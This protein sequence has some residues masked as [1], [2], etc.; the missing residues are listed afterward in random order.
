M[1]RES[2]LWLTAAAAVAVVVAA[3]VLIFGY[4]RPPDF[5]DLYA[6]GGPTV[7]GTVAYLEFN[8]EEC[9]WILD[10]ASGDS[11]ELYCDNWIW[12]EGW[13]AEGNLRVHADNGQAQLLLLDPDSGEVVGRE[14]MWDGPPSDEGG[15]PRQEEPLLRSRSTEGRVTLTHGT[16]ANAV[17]LIDIA[18]PRNYRF[19]LYG[20]TADGRYAWVW[21]SEDR[22]LLVA[23][24][25]DAEP[26]LVA[27]GISDPV[28]K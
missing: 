5:P 27:E 10:V 19:H 28:W 24:E 16:G 2:R 14:A 12:P 3:V 7:S 21:D 18:A 25:G 11:H 1:T 13:D 26:W 23:M 17:T 15:P 9:I 20:V 8:G 6:E 22:L 4:D